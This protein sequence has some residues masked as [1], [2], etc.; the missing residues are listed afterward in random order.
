VTG[1]LCSLA[2]T[3]C[4]QGTELDAQNLLFTDKDTVEVNDYFYTLLNDTKQLFNFEC[5][6]LPDNRVEPHT[7]IHCSKWQLLF[8]SQWYISRKN[9]N[10]Q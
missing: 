3:L 1:L 4:W 7:V 6:K 8:I 9:V 2:A 5:N 10:S